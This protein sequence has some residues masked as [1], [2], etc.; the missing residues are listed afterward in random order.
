MW[1]KCRVLEAPISHHSKNAYEA[2]KDMVILMINNINVRLYNIS[3]L[4]HNINH[5]ITTWNP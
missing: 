5:N 1:C 3:R 2:K 4:N